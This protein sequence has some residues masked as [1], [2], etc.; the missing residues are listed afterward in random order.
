MN[1][2]LEE[3]SRAKHDSEKLEKES[4][5][6]ARMI[7]EMACDLARV[8]LSRLTFRFGDGGDGDPGLDVTEN[9]GTAIGKFARSIVLAATEDE[10]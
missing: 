7:D 9:M 5:E 4:K 8:V 6:R 10:R 1:N 3:L 2:D